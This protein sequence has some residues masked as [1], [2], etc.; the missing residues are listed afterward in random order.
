MKKSKKKKKDKTRYAVMKVAGVSN[1]F[2]FDEPWLRVEAAD[3]YP[4]KFIN[5]DQADSLVAEFPNREWYECR[6]KK[7]HG[8]CIA[9]DADIKIQEE[10][11]IKQSE[12]ASKRK[13]A[14]ALMLAAGALPY[15]LGPS[16]DSNRKP[17]FMDEKGNKF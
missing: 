10:R 9:T 1:V 14:A 3:S 13:N 8:F 12:A 6:N 5:K 2:K 17:I 16:S 11:A 15:I 4:H 7:C